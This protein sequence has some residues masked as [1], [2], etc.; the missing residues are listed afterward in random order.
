MNFSAHI[1]EWEM[2]QPFRIAGVEWINTR[3]LVVQL[4]AGGH[5]GR[6][7]A[8]GVYYLDETAESILAEVEAVA[9]KIGPGFNRQDLQRLLP[10]GGARNALDC[11]LWDLEC[12]QSRKSIWQL[13][14]INPKPVTTVFTIGIESTAAAMAE[15]AARATDAPVLKV[16]LDAHEPFEKLAAVRAARPD[17][18]LVVD[19][20]QG[21]DFALLKELLPRCASLGLEMIEQP[22]KRGSDAELEGFVSPI[23]LCADES[24]LHTG[25]LEVAARRYSMIN[26][27]LDKTGGLT[28]ALNLAKAARAKGCKLMV[29]NMMGTSLSMVPS[30]LIAQLCDFMDLDGPLLLKHDYPHGLRYHKGV[31]TNEGTTVWG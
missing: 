22:L 26:I 2:K 25:E 6:G 28:E 20:N 27:K 1:E 19:A 17:A 11:A 14:G 4:S 13:T 24:C 15:K 5:I 31:V 3:S 8:Q 23:T 18:K 10:P 12:K 29:G 30:Y 9:G 21:W 16:K 7:E